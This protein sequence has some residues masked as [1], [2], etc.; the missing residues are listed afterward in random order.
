MSGTD[1]LISIDAEDPKYYADLL[2]KIP[3]PANRRLLSDERSCLDIFGIRNVD[4]ALSQ[5]LQTVLD[6]V[7]DISLCRRGNVSATMASLKDNTDGFETQLYIVFDREDESARR[8]SQHLQN[9]ITLLRVDMFTL[10][11][12][13]PSSRTI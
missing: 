3:R 7:A 10:R 11:Y 12:V 8:C 5:R 2:C 9:I 1:E 6:T 4:V 13:A